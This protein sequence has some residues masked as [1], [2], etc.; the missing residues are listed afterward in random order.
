MVQTKLSA[1]LSILSLFVRGFLVLFVC[2]FHFYT[3][4]IVRIDSNAI[5]MQNR[6]APATG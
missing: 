2:P 6:L 1:K 4:N 5:H 3:S